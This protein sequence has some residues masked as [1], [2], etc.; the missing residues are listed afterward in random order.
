LPR[1]RG[2]SNSTRLCAL[3]GVGDLEWCGLELDLACFDLREVEHLVDQGE[4]GLGG[5]GDGAGISALLLGEVGIEQEAR[6]AE[7]AAHRRSDLVAHRGEE[8]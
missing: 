5:G 4:Q 3:R 6:H 1:A 2:A 7:N 8:A